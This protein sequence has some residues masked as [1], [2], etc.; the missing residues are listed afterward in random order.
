MKAWIIL[1]LA[2]AAGPAFG[3][4][5]YKC[6]GPDGKAVYQQQRCPEGERMI[7]RDNGSGSGGRETATTGAAGLRPSEKK[8]LE[9]SEQRNKA[10]AK[11]AE[12]KAAQQSRAA[13]EQQRP[14]VYR[15]LEQSE[16]E[17]AATIRSLHRLLR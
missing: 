10:E 4:K 17:S 12:E 5:V 7:V 3:Q 11:A 13:A 2:L 15:M 8:M 14:N 1:G 6:P 9:Q 16:K